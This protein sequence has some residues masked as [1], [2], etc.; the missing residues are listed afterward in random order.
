M[1][2][3]MNPN[4]PAPPSNPYDF[5]TNP[6]QPPKR[7]GVGF[8]SS[9]KQRFIIVIGGAVIF[10][11]LVSIV[12]SVISSAGKA[13]I[14]ALRSLAVDQ[15]EIARV[16]GLG[17]KEARDPATR[18]F[19]ATTQMSLSSQ[20]QDT[21]VYLESQGSEVKSDRLNAGQNPETDKD[22]A[23]AAANNRYDEVFKATITQLLA[24]YANDLQN[25]FDSTD[26][27]TLKG[28]LK[29]SYDSASTLLGPPE[30]KPSS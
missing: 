28:L 5:I 29:T 4:S 7:P 22:L 10:M 11:I 30:P 27:K 8:G 26:S 12:F 16:A 13:P 15:Q 3:L 20:L 1:L 9:T 6:V 23:T 17:A 24:A 25:I 2:M 18:A 21:L 19:A 14:S